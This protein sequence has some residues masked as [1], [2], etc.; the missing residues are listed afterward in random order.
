MDTFTMLCKVCSKVKYYPLYCA[1]FNENRNYLIY[2]DKRVVRV[3][4]WS[5]EGL[6]LYLG[7]LDNVHALNIYHLVP[8]LN[9]RNL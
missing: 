1:N 5:P 9:I 2:S 3:L 8:T 6:H 7:S 4:D